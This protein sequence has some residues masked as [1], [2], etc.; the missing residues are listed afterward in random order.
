MGPYG[1]FREVALSVDQVLRRLPDLLEKA[2]FLIR[3]SMEMS[4]IF[5]DK[6]GLEFPRYVILN[7]LHPPG[8]YKAFIEEETIGLLLPCNMIVYEKD[9]VTIAGTVRPTVMMSIAKND[10]LRESAGYL[11]SKL[12]DVIDSL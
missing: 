4:D 5:R 1:Y 2:G 6:L 11:E 3:N 7:V 9:S 8:T 12:K 10:N